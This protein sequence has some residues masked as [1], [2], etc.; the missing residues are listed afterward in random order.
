M[1]I[2]V[3]VACALQILKEMRF[4]KIIIMNKEHLIKLI[5]TCYVSQYLNQ[6][7]GIFP[8]LN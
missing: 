3:L 7:R 5:D 1:K 4:L 8:E 6:K 2:Y